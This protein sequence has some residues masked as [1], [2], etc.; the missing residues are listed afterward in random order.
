MY[1]IGSARSS[2]DNLWDSLQKIVTASGTNIFEGREHLVKRAVFAAL[3]EVGLLRADILH[4]IQLSNEDE[5]TDLAPIKER[6]KLCAITCTK[7]LEDMANL[8]S[9]VKTE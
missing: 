3:Y 1:R 5:E 7:V 8:A 2:V 9:L 4:L 6:I